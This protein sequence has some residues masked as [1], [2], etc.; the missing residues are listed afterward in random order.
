[1]NA[2]TAQAR[3]KAITPRPGTPSVADGYSALAGRIDELAREYPS[4]SA[5]AHAIGMSR[6]VV[7]AWCDCKRHPQSQSLMLI[8]M[9]LNVWPNWLLLGIGSKRPQV[10]TSVT[11]AMEAAG[12]EAISPG[13]VRHAL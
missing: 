4:R 6:G 7:Y 9:K 8:C 13:G 10:W 5:F 11:D 12:R 1:M 3:Y 2:K